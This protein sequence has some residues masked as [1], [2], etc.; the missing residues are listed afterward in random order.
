MSGY[1]ALARLV[2]FRPLSTPIGPPSYDGSYSSPFSASWSVTV[3]DLARELGHLN[4]RRAVLELAMREQD[5]RIDGLPR[6]NARATHPGVVLSLIGSKHG[7]LRYPAHTF[8]DW[9]SN[10]RAI[11]LALEALRKVDRYGVTKLGQQYAG[12]RALPASTSESGALEY[13]RRIIARHGSVRAALRA[14]H[15]DTRE[16]GYSDASFAAVQ[17]ARD[18]A[19][20]AA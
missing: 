14:T 18:A 6:A 16:E 8:H 5:F 11:A 17:A 10:V 4:P 9:Q 7:D 1:E 19:K 12:W 20:A 13:G 2:E 15:P 3:H